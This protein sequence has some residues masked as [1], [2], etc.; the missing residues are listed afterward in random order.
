[1]VI[2]QLRQ[3]ACGMSFQR[4]IANESGANGGHLT[5]IGR[6]AGH[7]NFLCRIQIRL[8]FVRQFLRQAF[9]FFIHT[10]ADV[11]GFG[12]KNQFAGLVHDAVGKI[13][14]HALDGRR[15]D[16]NRQ[17]VIVAGGRF[18]TQAGFDDGENIRRIPAIAEPSSQ[19]SG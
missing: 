12:F 14:S 19:A 6:N 15:P 10:G 2:V 1:M 13:Q 4:L 5:L 17:Q 11:K 3:A 7:S 18:V 8:Q 9:G 16:F